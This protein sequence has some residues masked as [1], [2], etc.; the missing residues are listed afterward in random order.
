EVRTTGHRLSDEAL[1]VGLDSQPGDNGSRRTVWHFR[2]RSGG[3]VEIAGQSFETDGGAACDEAEG[4][5]RRL[6]ARAGS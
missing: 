1:A 6:A 2:F 5:A 3:Q 4:F